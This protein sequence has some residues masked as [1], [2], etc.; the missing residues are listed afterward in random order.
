[1]RL[2]TSIEALEAEVDKEKLV[3]LSKSPLRVLSSAVL[4]GGLTRAKG[5]INV[6]VPKTRDLEIHKCAEAFLKKAAVNLGLD[7]EEVVGLMTA[8]DLR[9]VGVVNQKQQDTTLCALVTAGIRFSATAGEATASKLNSQSIE[10]TCTINIIL[11]IDGNLTEGCMVDAAKTVTEAKTVVM[12]ELDVRSD[13]SGD[14]A[15]GT[16]TDSIVVACTKKGPLIKY[17]GTGTM[18]GELI[19]KSVKDSLK[20]AIQKQGKMIA[21]RSLIKRLE[22]RGI[23]FTKTT[24]LFSETHPTIY[25][26]SKKLD[27]FREE[28]QRVFSDPNVAFF[29]IT[30]LRLDEDE[31]MG[32]IPTG[33]WDKS[34]VDGILRTSLVDYLQRKKIAPK[35]LKIEDSSLPN[36]EGVGTLTRMVLATIMSYVCSNVNTSSSN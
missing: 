31:K 16:V 29:V 24:A 2:Y 25:G 4:N 34:L 33:M 14:F 15:S 3:I 12:R 26:N 21:N 36:M 23:S 28:V 5:I 8:A 11:I 10:K 1:M 9:K 22:E 32:L 7:P 18:L 13:F 19:G 30:A 35:R 27:N 20:E 17:A 6:H